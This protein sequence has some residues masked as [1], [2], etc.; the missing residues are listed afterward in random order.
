VE[1]VKEEYKV[2][3]EL[4]YSFLSLLITFC[5]LEYVHIVNP[6][7]LMPVMCMFKLFL[8]SLVD[9]YMCVMNIILLCR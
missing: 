4:H 8:F 2:S 1:T 6:L 9:N 5:Y 7:T 3:E